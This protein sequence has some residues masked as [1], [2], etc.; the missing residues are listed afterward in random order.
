MLINVTL[1]VLS[2]VMVATIYNNTH[3]YTYIMSDRLTDRTAETDRNKI[4]DE[5]SRSSPGPLVFNCISENFS[6]SNEPCAVLNNA[7]ALRIPFHSHVFSHLAK[8]VALRSSNLN[9]KL[10]LEQWDLGITSRY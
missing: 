8:S 5:E 7:L 10:S 9:A 3:I 2:T 1:R 4:G 6:L